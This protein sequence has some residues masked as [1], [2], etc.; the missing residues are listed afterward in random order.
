LREGLWSSFTIR[1]EV[2]K[3]DERT[4]ALWQET[5]PT[6]KEYRQ[7]IVPRD[8][9]FSITKHS[10]CFTIFYRVLMFVAKIDALKKFFL[11]FLMFSDI[12]SGYGR[13]VLL[14]LYRY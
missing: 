8:I 9:L 11:C 1:F 2:V 13:T 14:V 4:D 6:H 7:W 3:A 12:H 10:N 5:T